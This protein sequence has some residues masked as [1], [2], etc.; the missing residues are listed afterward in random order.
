MGSFPDIPLKKLV[1]CSETQEACFE[2]YG[3]PPNTGA[4]FMEIM[5]VLFPGFPL[6]SETTSFGSL[7]PPAV[8]TGCLQLGRQLRCGSA[9][10]RH[11]PA[12]ESSGASVALA[13]LLQFLFFEPG[14]PPMGQELKVSDRKTGSLSIR[15]P[16]IVGGFALTTNC[17]KI[18]ARGGR[19]GHFVGVVCSR[20]PVYLGYSQYPRCKT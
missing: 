18:W 7:V 12:L 2:T 16:K 17:L 8:S 9:L 13:R 1:G 3:Q 15:G 5:F 10:P 11:P 4:P 14:E 20:R 19:V 6:V